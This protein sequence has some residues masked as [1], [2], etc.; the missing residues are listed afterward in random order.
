[1]LKKRFHSTCELAALLWDRVLLCDELPV[2]S[3][4]FRVSSRAFLGIISNFWTLYFKI[5]VP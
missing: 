5:Q 2:T 4:C 3:G 1:M